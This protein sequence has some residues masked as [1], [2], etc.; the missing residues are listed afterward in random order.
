M[1]EDKEGFLYPEIDKSKCIDCKLCDKVCPINDSGTGD[2]AGERFF[3]ARAMEDDIRFKS[4]SGG[5]FS[6]LA[7]SVLKDNGIVFGA[8]MD[9][10]FKVKHTYIASID[11]IDKLRRTKY[12]QSEIGNSFSEVKAFLEEGKRVLFVGTPCQ[13]RGLQLYL[14]RDYDNLLLADL[15]CYG[16]P[17]PAIWRKYISYLKLR[18]GAKPDEF[19]FRD[20]RN[21]DHAHTVVCKI[22]GKEHCWSINHDPYS[23]RYFRNEIIRPSCHSCKFCTPF[24]KS[25]LTLGDFWGIEKCK[26]ELDDGMGASLVILHNEKGKAAFENILDRLIHFECTCED[27]LQPRLCSPTEPSP[28]RRREMLLYRTL[29]FTV[30]IRKR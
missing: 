16:A 9:E 8:C 27:A 3:G 17:S 4:S 11:D 15:I 2:N 12:V 19:S 30:W 20:K 21:H 18:Y 13:C 29:P 6:L 5:V 1:K 14:S 22:A 28:N 7:E 26:P 25:N 24:R 10:D 23:K